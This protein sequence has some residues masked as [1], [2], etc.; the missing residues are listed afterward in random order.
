MNGKGAKEKCS[1][2]GSGRSGTKKQ[3]TYRKGE[4]RRK[5]SREEMIRYVERIKTAGGNDVDIESFFSRG[6]DLQD[7][8]NYI[9]L[10]ESIKPFKTRKWKWS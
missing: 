2:S 8:C 3:S 5:G 9:F 4:G 7:Y 6:V 10:S 1:G